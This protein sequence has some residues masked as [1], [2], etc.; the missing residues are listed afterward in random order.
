METVEVHG[1]RLAYRR[2]GHGPPVMFVHG[3]VED[4]RAWTPQLDALSDEFTVIAWDEPGAGGS[5]DV[6]DEFGLSDYAD[7][8][9]GMVRALVGSPTSVV[10]LSW[11]TT[12]I[13]EM[14]RRHPAAIRGM[15]LAD[16]YAGWRGSLGPRE[17]DARLAAR[18]LGT[19]WQLAI[20]ANDP[21]RLAR[22]WAV[23][24]GYQPVPPV[25]RSR[26]GRR[27]IADGWGTPQLLTTGSSIRRE[28]DRPIWF[29]KVPES[30]AGKNRL[31]LDVY[32][33]GRDDTLTMASGSRSSTHA[34]P[35]SF[36]SAQAWIGERRARS[37]ATV[38]LRRMR[39]P[40][41]A[42]IF[43]LPLADQSFALHR[44]GARSRDPC[45]LK[46]PFRRG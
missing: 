29:Q 27:T 7:C 19:F 16:G 8:L 44:L 6:P 39:D 43:N 11:G 10:G 22:F 46:C 1:L 32:P 17:A 38:L 26:L 45:D 34:S 13:L 35:S 21:P 9:A 5:Q 20:D 37:R 30:K 2:T 15:V 40:A 3:G 28:A 36:A 14:Y 33:T 31:H 25:D 41:R 23:V 18:A 24:L 42:T 12:V 4:S